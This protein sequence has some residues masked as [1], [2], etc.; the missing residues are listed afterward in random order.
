MHVIHDHRLVV[1]SRLPYQTAGINRDTV[2]ALFHNT[3]GIARPFGQHQILTI[4][5]VQVDM[6]VVEVEAVPG[7]FHD[8][9]QQHIDT[10]HRSHLL[11]HLGRGLQVARAFFHAR[12]E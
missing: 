3:P 4:R 11:R 5:V 1:A 8:A 9:R 12:F 6:R 7:E 2:A 10:V